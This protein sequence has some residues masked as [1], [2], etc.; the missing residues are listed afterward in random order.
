MSDVTRGSIVAKVLTGRTAAPLQRYRDKLEEGQEAPLF[1]AT[2]H[3]S[4]DAEAQILQWKAVRE[5]HGTQG[6]TRKVNDSYEAVDPETGIHANGQRGTHVRYHDGKQWRKRPVRADETPTHLLVKA[7]DLVRYEKESEA[8]HTIYSAGRD[9]VNPDS[10]EDCARF[11]LAVKAMRDE[12]YPGIQESMWL[13]RNGESGNV[14]VHVASNST[15]YADFELDGVQYKAGHKMAGD[16]LRVHAVRAAFEQFLDAH[17]EYGFEQSFARV[18]TKE[19]AEAQHRDGQHSYWEAKR[20]GKESQQD[21][22]RRAIYEALLTDS[23]HDRDSFVAEMH[24]RGVAVRETGLRRGVA[25]RNHD[26]NYRLTSSGPK[27]TGING[28]TLG[29]EYSYNAIDA[30]LSLKALSE[31]IE[32]PQ[33]KQ[34]IGDRRLLPFE[35]KPWSEETQ[36]D[37]EKLVADIKDLV[38]DEQEKA[39]AE[40]VEKG[41]LTLGR[42]VVRELESRRSAWSTRDLMRALDRRIAPLRETGHADLDEMREDAIAAA[43][44]RLVSVLGR[45][46]ISDGTEHVRHW[47]TQEVIDQ[48]QAIEESLARRSRHQGVDGEVKVD[49]GTFTLA[50]GQA[51]AARMLTGTHRVAAIEGAAGSG[52]TSTLEAANEQLMKTGR[53]MVVVSPTKKGAIEAGEAIDAEGN[54]VHSMLYRAGAFMDPEN[55]N[56]W[57]LPDQ[58]KEQPPQWRMDENTVLVVDE[59]GM[60]DKA[61]AAVLHKYVDDMNVGTYAVMGD[62][63]QLAAVGRSGYLARAAELSDQHVVL[64]ELQRFRTAE[65][66]LDEEYAAATLKQRLRQRPDAFVDLLKRRDQLVTDGREAIIDGVAQTVVEELAAGQDSLAISATN[67]LNQEINHRILDRLIERGDIDVSR[68]VTGRDGDRIAVGAKVATRKNNS[69]FD[70]ANRETWTVKEIR[71]NGGI[72]VENDKG[73]GRE[74]SAAYVREDVQLAWALT[75]H[76]AQGMTVDRAHLVLTDRTDAAGLYVSLTRG[77]HANTVHA[78]ADD[79]QDARRQFRAATRRENADAGL[80]VLGEQA[81]EQIAEIEATQA[82]KEQQAASDRRVTEAIERQE[83]KLKQLENETEAF[84]ERVDRDFDQRWAA[85][86]ADREQFERD[87]QAFLADPPQRF[88]G[89]TEDELARLVAEKVIV[90]DDRRSGYLETMRSDDLAAMRREHGYT[91][92]EANYLAVKWWSLGR[93]ETVQEREAI[94]ARAESSQ[95]VE[96]T[97]TSQD[98]T[99]DVA[100]PTTTPRIDERE[101]QQSPT[102]TFTSRLRGIE[103]K[104]PRT[105]ERLDMLAQL[106]EDYRGR[107]PDAAFEQRLVEIGGVRRQLLD[108]HGDAMSPGFRRPLEQRAAMRDDAQM[109]FDTRVA[110]HEE[111]EDL[112]QQNLFGQHDDRIEE[113]RHEAEFNGAWAKDVRDLIKRGV[114]SPR[115][116][117][118]DLRAHRQETAS[119]RAELVPTAAEQRAAEAKDNLRA[120]RESDAH[121]A[122]DHDQGMGL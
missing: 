94:A 92:E 107:M 95:A 36:R 47:T 83:A 72:V 116:Y 89:L 60:L 50:D 78:V 69:D 109:A 22:I 84:D 55:G 16:L 64:E 56:A 4:H 117:D 54:S 48:E 70:V 7:D 108:T 122:N 93:P 67:A 40:I 105:R 62:S 87:R 24:K 100:M 91:D 11:F 58:W 102:T 76:G 15:I 25:G 41:P 106:E 73:K 51:R 39:A 115:D 98:S 33:G 65:G 46:V 42:S 57:V 96:A 90:K 81:E 14:H 75:G 1:T 21:R 80:H 101:E 10:V 82:A 120:D 17:Q 9:L 5:E 19:Y 121:A 27:S 97:A 77:R 103:V 37:Y 2:R 63:K 114:Y 104:S 28:K 18:G 86:D 112:Q 111:I 6:A 34:K 118:E 113:L 61:T 74:L 12:K 68:T 35:G 99:R 32:V 3:C 119:R 26:Y 85:Q 79:E 44:E 31:E 13:E 8:T 45:K 38:E 88:A 66:T 23:V 30:Q 59:V 43:Q 71:D 52:K 53:R 49:R 20:A 29:V 110:H